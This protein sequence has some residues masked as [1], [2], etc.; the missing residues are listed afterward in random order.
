MDKNLLLILI[1]A[2]TALTLVEESG[3]TGDLAAD[4]R[5][6]NAK[7]RE[8]IGKADGSPTTVEDVRLAAEAA[9]KPLDTLDARHAAPQ[10]DGDPGF[11]D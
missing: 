2:L 1:N 6:L 3:I 9:R 7:F 10:A 5:A 11:E 8:R 4:V